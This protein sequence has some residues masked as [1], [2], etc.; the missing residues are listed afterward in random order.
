MARDYFLFDF[1][2]NSRHPKFF[3]LRR[4]RRDHYDVEKQIAEFFFEICVVAF[5]NCAQNFVAFLFETFGE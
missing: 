3:L 4:D 5:S 2:Q 1:L